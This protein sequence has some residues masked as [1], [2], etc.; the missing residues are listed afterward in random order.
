MERYLMRCNFNSN[1]LD[2]SRLA[3]LLNPNSTKENALTATASRRLMLIC[4]PLH[5]SS[6]IVVQVPPQPNIVAL[7]SLVA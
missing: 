2:A 3:D 5:L 6:V 7:P 4:Y 1:D